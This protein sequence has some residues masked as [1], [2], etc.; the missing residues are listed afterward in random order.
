MAGS[1]RV[2]TGQIIQHFPLSIHY[3]E[4]TRSIPVVALSKARSC[5]RLLAGIAGSYPAGGMN[6]SLF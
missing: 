2:R 4:V 5:D 1:V 6:V 3:P